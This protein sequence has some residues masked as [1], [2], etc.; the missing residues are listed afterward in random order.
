[1]IVL[2][3]RLCGPVAR[4][5]GYRSRG[6]GSIPGAIR[7]SEKWWV[8]NGIYSASWV[9]LRSY[10]NG[11]SSGIGSRNPRLTVVWIR[12]ADHATPSIRKSLHSPT[13]SGRSVGRVRLRT[14]VTKFSLDCS[15][16]RSFEIFSLRWK[17]NSYTRNLCRIASS[18]CNVFVTFT[19]FNR[20][21]SRLINLSMCQ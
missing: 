2:Y 1:M 9:W 6:P 20:N 19:Y 16:Q 7:F 13:S 10:L 17:L 14:K 21:W 5:S 3:D 15:L 18:S 12:C 4:V 8:W 11:K